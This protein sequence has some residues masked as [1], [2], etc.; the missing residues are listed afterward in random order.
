MHLVPSDSLS[1]G[2]LIAEITVHFDRT[3]LQVEFVDAPT[4]VDRRLVSENEVR[5]QIIWKT[6]GYSHPPSISSMVSEYS[7]WIKNNKIRD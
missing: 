4:A 7:S 1:K 6:A 2:E 5:N 3:D